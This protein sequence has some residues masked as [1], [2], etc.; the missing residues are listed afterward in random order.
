M[1]AKRWKKR[2]GRFFTRT[3]PDFC[4]ICF[5]KISSDRI[6]FHSRVCVSCFAEM[7]PAIRKFEVEGAIGWGFYPYN[8]K[9]RNLLYLFKGCGDI[10]LKRVF[11][12]PY[13][14][15]IRCFFAGY[16]IVPVPSSE[17]SDRKRGFNHVEE[18]S[19]ILNIPI[20]R[21]IRKSMDVKQSSLPRGKREDTRNRFEMRE[22]FSLTGK[23]VL[24]IDDVMTTGSTIR[25]CI[26]LLKKQKTRKIK[27]I[28]MSYVELCRTLIDEKSRN[29]SE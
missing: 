24:L 20:V 6:R 7:D 4:L 26:L 3:D 27:F 11:F 25:A 10:E 5:R 14:R 1:S 8:E 22:G 21:C 9:I 2:V 28:V 19:K 29:L 23:K 16:V 18:M 13:R 15:W 12:D 17:S